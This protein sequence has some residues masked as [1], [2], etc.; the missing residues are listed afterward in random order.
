LTVHDCVKA[1]NYVQLPL[2]Y[3]NAV[4]HADGQYLYKVTLLMGATPSSGEIRTPTKIPVGSTCIWDQGTRLMPMHDFIAHRYCTI[5]AL[6]H[7]FFAERIT[8]ERTYLHS[9]IGN[10]RLVVPRAQ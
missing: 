1:C 4:D 9:Y 8:S 2:I 10:H 3:I 7:V 6:E 5:C